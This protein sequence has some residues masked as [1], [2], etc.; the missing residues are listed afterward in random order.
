MRRN[1]ATAV[2]VGLM[3]A[4]FIIIWSRFGYVEPESATAVTSANA[5]AG[6]GPMISPFEIM[7]KHSKYLPVESWDAF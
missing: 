3:A 2:T 6:A 1:I 4:A 5:A 7:A